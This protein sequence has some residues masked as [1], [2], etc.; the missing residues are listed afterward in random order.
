MLFIVLPE[1]HIF[2][3]TEEILHGE[4]T[5]ILCFVYGFLSPSISWHK[6]GIP[7]AM[8]QNPGI[9]T[10][11][12]S[13]YKMNDFEDIPSNIKQIATLPE[14]TVVSVLNFTSIQHND[15]A[16]YTCT[17]NNEV[18]QTLSSQPLQLFILGRQT[19]FVFN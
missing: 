8:L 5:T 18:E 6:N 12:Y 3:S 19:S 9:S 2:S 14:P 13:S 15:A 7:L 10:Y 16:N 4:P 1:V 17:A 11:N